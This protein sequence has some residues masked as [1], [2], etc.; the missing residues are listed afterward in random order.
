MFITHNMAGTTLYFGD[1]HFHTHYS[2][3]KDQASIEEMI[4]EGAAHQLSIFGTADHHHNLDAEKWRQ[5]LE[6]TAHLRQQYPDVL[7]LNNC[8]ITFLL[9]HL[10]V[11]VPEQIEGTI[12]EGYRYLYQ[13]GHALKI[14][15]HP[16][17]NT[18]EWHERLI[19]DA[20]GIEVINGSIFTHAQQQGYQIRSAIAIP[21]VHTYAAYLASGFSVAA[22]GSSDAHWKSDLGT[23]MTGFRLAEKPEQQ[24]VIDAILACRTFATTGNTC[25]LD[26]DFDPMKSEI[27]WK[28]WWKDNALITNRMLTIEVY[29]GDHKIAVAHEDGKISV[30]EAGLY[31]IAVFDEQDIAV[32]SPINVIGKDAV[33]RQ[34][35]APSEVLR[36]AV[37][38]IHRDLT[39][40]HAAPEQIFARPAPM[41]SEQ[42]L[43]LS[44]I[45]SHDRPEMLD[46]DGKVVAYEIIQK[47][48]PRVVIEKECD[49]QGFD[50]FYL[51]LRRNEIHEY[52]FAS[53][54]YHKTEDTLWFTGTLL[55]QKM[56]R[57]QGIQAWYRDNLGTLRTLV[58]TSNT[59]KVH[60]STLPALILRLHLSEYS[61]PLTA[62]DPLT[63]LTSVFYCDGADTM[64]CPEHVQTRLDGKGYDT[65]LALSDRMYQIFVCGDFYAIRLKFE[66]NIN[67]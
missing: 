19:P 31:W 57:C 44:V 6:E 29:H 21:S 66:T 51:W 11:L 36:K 5:T 56:V 15:N 58:E 23:G 17:P 53:I 26:W 49:A 35:S 64:L 28:V 14:I 3:N 30:N 16:F 27:A 7:I 32:S 41:V 25:V 63:K 45:F 12:A 52:L 33:T 54:R 60:V 67:V 10:N 1:L 34:T 43:E 50:E 65:H 38:G 24:T 18:D 37:Y 2:D 13:D 59:L 40:L 55:P 39:W 4:L 46:A 47:G 42:V 62:Y 9:G 61:L 20:V 22:I 8:E 48:S